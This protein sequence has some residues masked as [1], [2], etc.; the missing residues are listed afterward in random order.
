[1]D[2]KQQ[3]DDLIQKLN[4]IDIEQYDISAFIGFDGYIDHIQQQ[5][6][7][8]STAMQASTTEPGS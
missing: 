2:I 5:K 8:T 4:Q 6:Q 3:I 1:M 7:K